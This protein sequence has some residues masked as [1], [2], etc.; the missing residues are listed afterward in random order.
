MS[1][2]S[3]SWYMTE[4]EFIEALLL[5]LEARQD[6]D[7]YRKQHPEDLEA[8]LC[9]FLTGFVATLVSQGKLREAGE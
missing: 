1:N 8:N 7:Q 5:A 4:G 3:P 9:G 2:S 6:S